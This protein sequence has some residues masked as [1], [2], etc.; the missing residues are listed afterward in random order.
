MKN[1][2][3]CTKASTTLE[4][5]RDVWQ[6]WRCLI[7]SPRCVGALQQCLWLPCGAE[8]GALGCWAYPGTIL[9]WGQVL[10]L[11]EVENVQSTEVEVQS[12]VGTVG[13]K[14]VR[15]CDCPAAVLGPLTWQAQGARVNCSWFSQSSTV[16]F[17]TGTPILLQRGLAAV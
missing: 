1:S 9:T 7:R 8:M 12:R 17:S 3:T 15:P 2:W 4:T 10:L 16:L 5:Q 6:P 14:E 13:V 11:A